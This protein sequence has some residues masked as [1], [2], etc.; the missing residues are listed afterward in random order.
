MLLLRWGVRR[1][2]DVE[3]VETGEKNKEKRDEQNEKIMAVYSALL[4][5]VWDCH[6]FYGGEYSSGCAFTADNP[7]AY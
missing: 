6:C 1:K 5:F 4:V 2:T 3:N 7:K